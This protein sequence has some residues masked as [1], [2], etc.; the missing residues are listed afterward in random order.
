MVG[1]EGFE[2]PTLCSQSNSVVVLPY[3][4]LPY[5]STP[6]PDLYSC[7]FMEICTR[8]ESHLSDRWPKHYPTIPN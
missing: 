6:D 4:T 5:P 3:F 2:P 7:I 8:L 1:A